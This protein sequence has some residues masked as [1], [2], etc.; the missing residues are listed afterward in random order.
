MK[1]V[2]HALLF[3]LFL[4]ALSTSLSSQTITILYP[5]GGEV[6]T[7][8]DMELIQWTWTGAIDSVRVDY[9]TNGGGTWTPIEQKTLNDSFCGW[10]VPNKPGNTLLIKV[11]DSSNPSILD[12]S[13]NN[14]SIT[15]S[16]Q[17]TSPVSG[18][19]WEVG[20]LDTITWDATKGIANV[21]IDYST[22]GGTS[23][24]T[25][26]ASTPHNGIYP[27]NV[28]N[29]PSTNALV[30]V[31]DTDNTFV[32]DMS[33]IF[34]I[35]TQITVLSPNGGENWEVGSSQDITWD[36]SPGISDVKLEYSTNGGGSWTQLVASTL[37]T[38][39]YGW[40]IID[41]PSNAF[42]IKITDC[43]NTAITDMSDNNFTVFSNLNVI[44]PNGGELFYVGEEQIISYAASSGI[45]KVKFEYSTNNGTTWSQILIA[46]ND[47]TIIWNIP[48][49]PSTQCLVRITDN[50]VSSA[51]DASD[52]TFEINTGVKIE[53]VDPDL[54]VPKF[55]SQ[56]QNLPNPFSRETYIRYSLPIECHVR[57]CIYDISGKFI[58]SL[59]D[60]QE[61]MGY[62]TIRWNGTDEAG[63]KLPTG[64]YFYRMSAGT[65]R[66]TK[67]FVFLQ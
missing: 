60:K 48:N 53:E 12:I 62:K 7:P 49:K 27:W 50:S 39:V 4:L 25:I 10:N 23:W 36:A 19:N 54:P 44:S 11:T 17:I 33:D 66:D 57:I 51:S 30:R 20:T 2:P 58:R 26:I 35:S 5:N 16:I 13:D 43:T 9:S 21:K 46:E 31:T 65:F 8:G 40:K 34:N 28:P 14:F 67:K 47:S 41:V 59:V 6:L 61:K 22:N 55:F 15:S 38:G 56:S 1:Y 32:L 64:V 42:R 3:V 45:S 18:E 52:D 63:N 29:K 37:N 24:A